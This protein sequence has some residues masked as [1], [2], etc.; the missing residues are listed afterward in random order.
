MGDKSKIMFWHDL[1]CGGQPLKV[2][3]QELYSITCCK[4]VSV[5][6][7]QFINDTLQWNI[8]FF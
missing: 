3:F 8:T 2:T 4:E 5:E 6:N 1:L 7:V